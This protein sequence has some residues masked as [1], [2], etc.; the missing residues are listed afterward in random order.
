MVWYCAPEYPTS[1]KV[2]V[3]IAMFAAELYM[4][5]YGRG[6]NPIMKTQSISALIIL[7]CLNTLLKENI[8]TEN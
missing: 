5:T 1:Y 2:S 4:V 6:L 7:W 3:I 8:D